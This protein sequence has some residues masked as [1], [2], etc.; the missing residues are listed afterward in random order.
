MR[1]WKEFEEANGFVGLQWSWNLHL[2]INYW[3]KA[4]VTLKM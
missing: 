2:T 3:V 1:W 4:L